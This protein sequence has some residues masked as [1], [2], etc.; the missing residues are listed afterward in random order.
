M[1]ELRIE[2]KDEKSSGLNIRDYDIF[3]NGMKLEKLQGVNINM[4]IDEANVCV[5][6]MILD[7]IKVDSDFIKLLEMNI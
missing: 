2:K 5:L 4:E 7:N 1:A 6:E 3:L